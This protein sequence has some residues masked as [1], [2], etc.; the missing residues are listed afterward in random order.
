[1]LTAAEIVGKRPLR[2][3]VILQLQISEKVIIEQLI[4]L[5]VKSPY[6]KFSTKVEWNENR[7]LLKVEF[8]TNVDTSNDRTI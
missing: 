7:K 1:M 6:L 5:D 3:A 2:A 8:P 4:T